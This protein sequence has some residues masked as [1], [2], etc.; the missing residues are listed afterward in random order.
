MPVIEVVIPEALRLL[1]PEENGE[2]IVIGTKGY[3]LFPL[4]EGQVEEVAAVAGDIITG[5]IPEG[6]IEGK[7]NINMQNV[8]QTFFNTLVKE[9]K[10]AE[11]LSKIVGLDKNKIKDITIPQL[12]HLAS[13]IYKQNF[14]KDSLP[15]I[16]VKNFGSLLPSAGKTKEQVFIETMATTLQ[17]DT[18]KPETRI[19]MVMTLLQETWPLQVSTNNS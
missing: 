18:M 14:C 1:N 16:T 11:V 17:D 7:I 12:A 2:I 5:L 19:E 4:T 3:R 8:V 15:S 9:N 10:I 13:V 6:K